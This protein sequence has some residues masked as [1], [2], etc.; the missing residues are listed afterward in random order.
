VEDTTE[1]NKLERGYDFL[2]REAPIGNSCHP[3]TI[4]LKAVRDAIAAN[5]K[6]TEYRIVSPNGSFFVLN[7]S[8]YE[9]AV[10]AGQNTMP[11]AKTA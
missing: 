10:S 8:V 9:Y 5:P 3:Q 6:K 7:K 11:E 1:L 2:R 4:R